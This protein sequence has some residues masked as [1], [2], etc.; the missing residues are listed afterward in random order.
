MSKTEKL[1]DPVEVV[2]PFSSTPLSKWIHELAPWTHAVT[3]TFKR[4]GINGQ[5]VSEQIIVH[6]LR[7]F[8]RVLDKSY[9]SG[10]KFRQGAYVPS[11]VVIGWGTYNDHPHAHLALAC[12]QEISHEAFKKL[13]VAASEATEWIDQERRVETYRNDGWAEYM[14]NHGINNLITNLTRAHQPEIVG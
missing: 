5:A 8:L 12:R 11:A 3:L 9:Y 1:D 4:R 13:I 7:H 14:L 2:I 10:S 6:A